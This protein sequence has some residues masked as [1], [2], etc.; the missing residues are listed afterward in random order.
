MMKKI[1][2]GFALSSGLAASA[3][4]QVGEK[5]HFETTIDVESGLIGNATAARGV[6]FSQVVG[7]RGAGWIRLKFDV[8]RLGAAPI[9]GEPTVLRLTS[10]LDGARQHLRAA[11]LEQW[12]DTSAYFNG[13]AVL[14]EVLA[15]PGSRPSR[16]GATTA[17]VGPPDKPLVEMTICGASDDRVLS[18][19]SRIGRVFPN[20]CTAWLID[21]DAHCFLSAG[22]CTGGLS[23]VEFNV[24]LSDSNGMH[25]H[26]GP[27]DQ[28]AN[29]FKS[30]QF[31][32]GGIGNDW[33]YFGCFRNTET[34]LTAF[35]AQGDAFS[36]ASATPP[37]DGRRV[38][39][40]GYGSTSSPIP[41]EWNG[42][43]KTHAGL[44]TGHP[45]TRL[46][47]RTD[48]S[49]GNSGSP[50]ID[51]ETGLAIGIHTHA[52]CTVDGGSNRGTAIDHPDL[53]AALASPRGVCIPLLPDVDGNGVVDFADLVALFEAWGPCPL[54]PLAC[55]ADLNGDGTV[56]FA[57]LMELM[58]HWE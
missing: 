57:D 28:Y 8:A 52:G 50:V 18:N 40:T 13:N 27:E 46:E 2:V 39:V 25:Q 9:G 15:D 54:P 16:I 31:T 1:L 48:T 53:Q 3:V 42:A 17:W 41:P 22:H 36:L 43:Q 47:Y 12:S 51:D 21:D 23:G 11:H 34:G 35:Q 49:G 45:G 7:V 33:A 20:G 5:D 4:G 44:Y 30:R 37:A 32:N 10:L 19:D 58:S 38:R 55:P 14:V 26:P 56:D 24:P 29:D 6:I